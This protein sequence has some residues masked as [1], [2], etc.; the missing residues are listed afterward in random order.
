VD[1][2]VAAEFRHNEMKLRDF[3]VHAKREARTLK[4]RFLNDQRASHTYSEIPE[5]M[6][7]S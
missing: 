7:V 4:S 1:S 2:L 6:P 3:R 5:T